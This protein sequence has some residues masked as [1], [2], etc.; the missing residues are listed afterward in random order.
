MKDNAEAIHDTEASPELKPQGKWVF[1]RHG[2]AVY[3]IYQADETEIVVPE[4][5]EIPLPETP[6]S[7]IQLLG[8]KARIKHKAQANGIAC[9]LPKGTTVASGLSWVFKATLP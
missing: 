7:T 6:V 8:S 4:T 3:A 5:I 1:T 2:K 9:S